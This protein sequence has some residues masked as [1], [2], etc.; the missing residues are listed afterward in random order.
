MNQTI[1]NM[2]ARHSC[3]SYL[4]D[5]VDRETIDLLIETGAAAARGFSKH[6]RKFIVI[7]EPECLSKVNKA[8]R[9][10]YRMIP[11]TDEL[12]DVMKAAIQRAVEND[13]A[14]FLFGAPVFVLI[15]VDKDDLNGEATTALALGNMM[16][17]AQSMG[18]GSC[19]L[20]QISRMAKLPPIQALLS[21]LGVPETDA[22]YGTLVVGSPRGEIQGA[23]REVSEV[24]F[25][26]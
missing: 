24:V 7:T 6:P 14:V 16:V 10:A 21:E 20:N 26:D 19:W 11:I 13:D 8:V 17:A 1:E 9:D 22:V 2:L 3:R 4:P 15:S 18:L 25:F 12:P 23:P 5:A